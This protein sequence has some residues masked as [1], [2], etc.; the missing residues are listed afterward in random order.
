METFTV[1]VEET[2]CSEFLVEAENEDEA[3]LLARRRYRDGEYVLEPGEL[4]GARLCVV[5]ASGNAEAWEPM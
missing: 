4:T 3:W 1:I 2:V 5:D